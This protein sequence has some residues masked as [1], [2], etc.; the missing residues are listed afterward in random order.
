MAAASAAFAVP[1]P[2]LVVNDRDGACST[3]GRSSGRAGKGP[4]PGAAE[5]HLRC[6]D[7]AAAGGSGDGR[8]GQAAQVWSNTHA[9]GR[10]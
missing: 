1:L 4:R 6:A 8:A 10:L 9:L 5:P 7:G 3:A 2:L